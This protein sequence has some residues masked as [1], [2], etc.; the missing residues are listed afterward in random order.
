MSYYAAQMIRATAK[1][2]RPGRKTIR[3]KKH[4]DYQMR[5]ISQ[6]EVSVIV[7]RLLHAINF[8]RQ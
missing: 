7:E 3:I 6:Q 2:E 4:R 5:E 1:P 8:H